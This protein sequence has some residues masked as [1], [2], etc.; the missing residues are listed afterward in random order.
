MRTRGK[1]RPDVSFPGDDLKTPPIY[2]EHYFL[3]V[4]P[5]IVKLNPDVLTVAPS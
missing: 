5:I 2:I 4:T 1:P 3:R